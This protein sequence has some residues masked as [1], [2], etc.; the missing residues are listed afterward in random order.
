M[1]KTDINNKRTITC[2]FNDNDAYRVIMTSWWIPQN[3]LGFCSIKIFNFAD[4]FPFFNFQNLRRLVH[5]FSI[6]QTFTY[7]QDTLQKKW[8]FPLRVSSVDLVTFTEEILNG[9][10]HFLCSDAF[11]PSF[12]YLATTLLKIGESRSFLLPP[13]FENPE[14]VQSE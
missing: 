7:Q 3:L 8:S 10:L 9:K 6:S 14:M 4:S 11:Y 5:K 2:Q 1:S 12:M 13:A